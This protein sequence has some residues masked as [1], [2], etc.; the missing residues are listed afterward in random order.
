MAPHENA[1]YIQRASELLRVSNA[2]EVKDYAEALGWEVMA[3]ESDP[4]YSRTTLH[5]PGLDRVRARVR[6]GD[7]DVV[8]A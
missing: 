8:L 2:L 6:A 4:G 1:G 3:V 5:R 7:V